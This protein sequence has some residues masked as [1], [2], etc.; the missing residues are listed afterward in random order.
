MPE[1]K[2]LNNVFYIGLLS[3]FGGISQDI[4]V[5]I[6]P[7][8]LS[9]VL[10]FDKALIGVSE[11]LV[12]SGSSIFR[13]IS[14]FLVDKFGRKK[15]IIFV[16]YFLSMIARPALALFSSGAA[17]LSLRFLDGI[18]KG[19]KD[20]PKD[21]LIAD[22]TEAATRGKGF[23]IARMLDTFG[24][25]AGPLLLFGLLYLLR[26]QP[27]KYYTILFLTAIP[28]LVTLTILQLKVRETHSQEKIQKTSIAGF[29]PKNFYVFLV[30]MVVF[31]IGNSSDA[32][33]ILRAQNVGVALLTI[34]LVYALFNFVYA[35]ASVPLGSLSDKIGRQKVIAVGLIAFM[36][37]YLG[38]AFT[39][40]SYQI[41]LL[42]AF[43]GLYYAT[44]EGVAKA[45]VADMVNPDYRGRAYGIYNTTL[46]LVTLPSNF[47]AGLLWDRVNPTAPFFFGAAMALI[48]I[49]L[50]F[51]FYFSK[52]K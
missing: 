37:A 34:P 16:G 28:L 44:T 19:M 17:I 51:L 5:P 2:N 42:F 18:G 40:A 10:L 12:T 24:S 6:L 31:G 41:W 4:F 35:S 29:L 30:I 15:P 21:A 9:N 48:A 27:T 46:G 23:G 39:T 3:F 47:I 11:G 43:Y 50:L 22:S 45:F 13:I 32:F 52:I 26:N 20:S 49:C 38:F 7:L 14:G 36:I 33:L 1:K 25:V 8:Y